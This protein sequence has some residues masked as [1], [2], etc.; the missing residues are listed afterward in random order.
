MIFVTEN[1]QRYFEQSGIN[2]CC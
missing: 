2:N 1:R